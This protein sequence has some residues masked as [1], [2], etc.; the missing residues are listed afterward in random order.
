MTE[1]F[2]T[3]SLLNTFKRHNLDSFDA[4]WEIEL[5]WFE[6]PNKRRSGWSGVSQHSLLQ[7]N[8]ES[9]NLFIKRQQNHNTPCLRHPIKGEPTFAREYRNIIKLQR[10]GIPTI[11]PVYFG[12]RRVNGDSQSILI[13]VAL[14]HYQTVNELF[15]K[16]ENQTGLVDAIASLASQMHQTG[17]THYCFYPNHIFVAQD[18]QG[19]FKPRLIDLEKMR[20]IPIASRRPKKDFVTFIR[21]AAFMGKDNLH[22]LLESYIAQS[23]CMRAGDKTYRHLQ[24]LIERL[25]YSG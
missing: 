6:E 19:A 16:V 18:E 25:D 9:L 2:S 17:L 13:S 14:D 24:A 8:G 21:R 4:L 22:R 5:P 11:D 3:D 20:Y 10:L 15:P 23:H 7:E 1:I 12:E